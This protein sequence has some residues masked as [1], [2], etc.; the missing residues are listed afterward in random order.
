[1]ARASLSAA[2]ASLIPAWC[3]IEVAQYDVAAC[4]VILIFGRLGMLFRQDFPN[5]KS[6]LVGRFRFLGPARDLIEAAQ[7]AVAVCQV[8]LIFGHLGMLFR[9]DFPN[10][11]SFLEGRFC[12]L[13]PAG[14]LIETPRSM[15]PA[16]RSR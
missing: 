16:S 4:Q 9:Q 1:M 15:W 2:S 13:G 10:G 6:F 8:I 12:F 11:K 3:L 5:G 14:G 7:V